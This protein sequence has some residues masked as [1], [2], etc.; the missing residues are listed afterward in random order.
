MESNF[1]L[2]TELNNAAVVL[3]TEGNLQGALS[4]LRQALFFLDASTEDVVGLRSLSVKV[5]PVALPSSLFGE[6][7]SSGVI[8]PKVYNHAF[9][10][11]ALPHPIEADSVTVVALYNFALI[12]HKKGI[13]EGKERLLTKARKIYALASQ[14]LEREQD[15]PAGQDDRRLV[16]LALENNLCSIFSGSMKYDMA[17]DA[18]GRLRELL[19]RETLV[20]TQTCTFYYRNVLSVELFGWPTFSSPSA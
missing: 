3:M 6:A 19:A 5:V 16:H 7:E 9:L 4:L 10:L 17:D 2:S 15:T 11:S 12:L 13:Y 8:Y 18:M 1:G 14:V 20:D